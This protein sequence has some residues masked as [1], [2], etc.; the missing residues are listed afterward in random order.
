MTF[1][2]LS[3]LRDKAKQSENQHECDF[4]FTPAWCACL[5]N[6][7]CLV[8]SAILSSHEHRVCRPKETTH[9]C[10]LGVLLGVLLLL[11]AQVLE[12]A[13]IDDL[14]TRCNSMPNQR[15][16]THKQPLKDGDCETMRLALSVVLCCMLDTSLWLLTKLMAL[17]NCCEQA[18]QTASVLRIR[19]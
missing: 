8:S 17:S 4:A 6:T 13:V 12:L 9:T 1:S 7:E 2:P 10:T 18:S 14:Q 11:L 16:I 3:S 19:C 15:P 5:G